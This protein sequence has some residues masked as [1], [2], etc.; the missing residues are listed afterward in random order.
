MFPG[1]PTL[2]EFWRMHAQHHMTLKR[3]VVAHMLRWHDA[4][5]RRTARQGL[6]VLTAMLRRL[7]HL[8]AREEV[9]APL[10]VRSDLP[11]LERLA[12]PGQR[13][14]RFRLIE[15]PRER[16]RRGAGPGAVPDTPELAHALVLERL[17]VLAAVYRRRRAIAR[18]LARR[19][20]AGRA[21]LYTPALPLRDYPRLPEGFTRLLDYL[22][23]LIERE[24]K[25]PP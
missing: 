7:L 4:A 17:F 2:D 14:P 25:P 5:I 18:R 22:D 3:F 16:P 21:T 1:A 10:S 13:H 19:V 12:P 20:Q 8:M 6:A 24:A 11:P 9:L 15:G 23:Y